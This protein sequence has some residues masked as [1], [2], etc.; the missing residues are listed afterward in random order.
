VAAAF[1]ELLE[2]ELVLVQALPLDGSPSPFTDNAFSACI[3]GLDALQ[4]TAMDYLT[5]TARR[6]TSRFPVPEPRLAIWPGSPADIISTV[7]RMHEVA[8][9]VMATH[10]RTGIERLLRGS[11][12]HDLLNRDTVPLLLLRPRNPPAQC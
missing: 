12:A 2:G 4:T 10:A 9:V 11:V 5:A 3:S 6:V 1:A 8:L 7:A